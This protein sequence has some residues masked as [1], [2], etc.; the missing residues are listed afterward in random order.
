MS[1][2]PTARGGGDTRRVDTRPPRGEDRVAAAGDH[3][4]KNRLGP[5]PTRNRI[6]HLFGC[7]L[8]E[9]AGLAAEPA[10]LAKRRRNY[11]TRP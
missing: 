10:G 1:R 7:R 9:A 11:L 4:A 5:L 2:C 3:D 8:G 6:A